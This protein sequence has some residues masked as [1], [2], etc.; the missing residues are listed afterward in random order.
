MS[1]T[2]RLAALLH[3]LYVSGPPH[4]CDH[5]AGPYGD[6]VPRCVEDA[7]RLIASGV[8]PA[9][10]P[11]PALDVERLTRALLRMAADLDGLTDEERGNVV[12]IMLPGSAPDD[13]ATAIARAYEGAGE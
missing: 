2:D 13:L 3:D 8:T 12:A 5:D 10:T 1:D 7:A 9:P 11:A 4:G 6:Y